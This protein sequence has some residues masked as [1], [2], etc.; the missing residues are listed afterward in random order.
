M[1]ISE[2]IARII[3]F[4]QIQLVEK[5]AMIEQQQAQIKELADKAQAVLDANEAQRL[6]PPQP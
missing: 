4:Q 6:P 2:R 1:D 5:D 3:G